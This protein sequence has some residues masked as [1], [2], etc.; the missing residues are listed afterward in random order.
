MRES[1]TKSERMLLNKDRKKPHT[2]TLEDCDAL[3]CVAL[4]GYGLVIVTHEVDVHLCLWVLHGHSGAWTTFCF[5][6][7]TL[8][9]AL[10]GEACLKYIS[11]ISLRSSV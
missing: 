1:F 11:D 4:T 6:L 9:I 7:I 2:C 3:C 8:A 10:E 5:N